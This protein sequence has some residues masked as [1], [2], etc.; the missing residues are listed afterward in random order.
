[1]HCFNSHYRYCTI[2]IGH[3]YCQRPILLGTGYWVAWLVSFSPYCW[4]CCGVFPVIIFLLDGIE[5]SHVP[6]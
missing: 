4:L 3:W 6:C 2:G 1:M 5:S